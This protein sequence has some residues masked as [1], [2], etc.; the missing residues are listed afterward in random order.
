MNKIP[1]DTYKLG[2]FKVNSI[3]GQFTF[4]VIIYN[5]LLC[6]KNFKYHPEN[7]KDHNIIYCN[8][9]QKKF[10]YYSKPVMDFISNHIESYFKL[11][12]DDFKVKITKLMGF[13]V[14]EDI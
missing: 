12:I 2:Y 13:N 3:K 4:T 14:K 6:F 1:F 11:D 8:V 7:I 9:V 10:M 5:G